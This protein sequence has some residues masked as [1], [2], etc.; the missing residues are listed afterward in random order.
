MRSRGAL[1]FSIAA[2]GEDGCRCHHAGSTLV[3]RDDLIA[4]PA[5][6]AADR[7][8]GFHR[9]EDRLAAQNRIRERL[10]ACGGCRVQRKMPGSLMIQ[11]PHADRLPGGRSCRYPTFVGRDTPVAPGHH[12]SVHQPDYGL[13]EP[14]AGVLLDNHPPEPAPLPRRT[15]RTRTRASAF[16]AMT[17][18]GSGVTAGRVSSMRVGGG[19]QQPARDRSGRELRRSWSCIGGPG[20]LPQV[21]GRGAGCRARR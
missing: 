11:D 6:M 20:E 9:T 14:T 5:G 1:L 21:H 10:P 4:G 18:R 7:P 19:P 17:Q 15:S 8:F 12:G 13:V 3:G 2:L 16:Q